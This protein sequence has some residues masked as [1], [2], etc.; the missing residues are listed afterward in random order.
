M[1]V[2]SSSLYFIGIGGTAM[3]AVAV[4]AKQAGFKVI[5]SDTKVYPPMSIFLDEHNIPYFDGFNDKNIVES[6]PDM[7]VIGN[8]I[9]RGN[10]ELEYVLEQRIPYIS[11]SEFVRNE[12]I[13]R[14][15][16]VVIT[17]THGKTTTSSLA[18]WVLANAGLPTGFM[19]GAVTGNFGVGSRPVALDSDTGGFFVT[20]GDEYDTCFFDKRSKF[21]LYRPNIAVVNNIEFDHADIFHS[22][23]EIK[24]SFKYFIRLV[25]RN[26]VIIANAQD[27]NVSDILPSAVSPIERFGL[28]DRTD[29]TTDWIGTI[30]KSTP[31]ETVFN[32][33]YK[34]NEYGTFSI[35]LAGEYN[36]MNCLSVIAVAHHC[37]LSLSQI[38]SGFSSFVLPKRRLEKIAVWNGVDVIDDFAHHPT[39]ISATLGGLRQRYPNNR[40]IACFEPR[41]NTTTR[42]YF[43][44]ELTECFG[45]ADVVVLGCVNRPER[46]AEDD[47]LDRDKLAQE[48][49][50]QGKETFVVDQQHSI[51]NWGDDVFK[52]LQTTIK[53]NDVIILLS[54]GDIGG[55]RKKFI[56]M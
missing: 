49:N 21:M 1:S 18:S 37:G 3:G 17:G 53:D 25:P 11:M 38:Q 56:A 8:A 12:F 23:D 30:S 35:G 28:S 14:H 19:I 33:T 27:K 52:Y 43:Q 41:S 31:S 24:Q 10:V 32:V 20:E 7:V 34:G 26:G 13:K 15:T 39:A 4:S 29:K 44:H 40:I 54:N 50:K 22:L 6:K 46:Y 9:S 47:R 36:V 42:A 48:L 5:G 45:M 16:S 55:L 2:S 51:S